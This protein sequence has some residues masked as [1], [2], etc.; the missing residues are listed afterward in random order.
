MSVQKFRGSNSLIFNIF[1]PTIT[2]C[3]ITCFA[4]LRRNNKFK[5][6]ILLTVQS[7][8]FEQTLKE[9][10]LRSD[11]INLIGACSSH[12]QFLKLI[13]R[14][15]TTCLAAIKDRSQVFD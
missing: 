2:V 10:T 14:F 12:V 13:K 6:R 9:S 11:C 5:I 7:S 8:F 3:H 1:S 15:S 4:I